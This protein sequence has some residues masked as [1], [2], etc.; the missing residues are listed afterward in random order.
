[1]LKEDKLILF[2]EYDTLF[3]NINKHEKNKVIV[4]KAICDLFILSIFNYK[5]YYD[6]NL[7]E[8]LKRVNKEL[9]ALLFLPDSYY[10]K[11]NYLEDA[12]L[13]V[14]KIVFSTNDIDMFEK[15]LG[16]VLEKYINR[17][18]TGSYYTP[19]DTT[20]FICWNA[21]LIKAL[22]KVSETTNKRICSFL[23]ISNNVEFVDKKLLFEEKINILKHNLNNSEIDDLT[24][25]ISKMKIID[26]MCGSGAFIVS[27]YNCIKF[28]NE[29]LLNNRLSKNKYYKNIYG[30]DLEEEAV[31]FA[32][33]RIILKSIIDKNINNSF[34]ATLNNNIVCGDALIEKNANGIN[35]SRKKYDCI[36]G[37]PPYV[38]VKNKE[39]YGDY[40]SKKCGNLYAYSIERACLI[41]KE[42]SVISFVVPLSFVSTARMS[43]IKQYLESKS[44]TIYYSTY[45]DRPG[46]LFTGVHQRLTIFF[47]QIGRGECNKYTSSYK[48]WY[49]DERKKLFID[50]DFMENRHE[51][52]PKI[53]LPIENSIYTKSR[54]CNDNI[55]SLTKSNGKYSLYIS[56]R[57][58]FWA[59]AFL[60]K[61]ETNEITELKFESDET[62][63]IIYCLINSSYFYYIWVICSDCWHITSA[64]LTNA[65]FNLNAISYKQ[66]QNLI[67]LSDELSRDLEKHKE[68]I[69]TKQTEF[70]YKH[71]Y[72]KKII[73]K[74][75]DIICP[76]VGLNTA[77]KKY[78]KNY[79]LKYRMNNAKEYT[80]D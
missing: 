52:M 62:R 73:D 35:W 36:I 21:I 19:E 59:K 69:N 28:L 9:K 32:K 51:Q 45:A 49:K 67:S 60:Y 34:L 50:L 1:M 40:V 33:T 63:R 26:P 47:S 22:T 4:T 79:T 3:S 5:N 71:K 17:K 80:E 6:G 64:D 46:C 12:F 70:E 56:S 38:E 10:K 55:N 13:F 11:N 15:T 20:K 23:N 7:Y 48:F 76:V 74:I 72:S 18:E 57:I 53:G 24:N 39:K 75:D 30:V 78:I 58:G 27:A 44:K 68:R 31:I 37:N 66:K 8:T 77:E 65:K 14:Q 2:K 61:P 29:K 54:I 25:A 16:Q 41:A 43:V 42:N